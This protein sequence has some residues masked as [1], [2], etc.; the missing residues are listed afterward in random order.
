[1][2]LKSYIK[3]LIYTKRDLFII[4][5]NNINYSIYYFNCN[6]NIF[7]ITIVFENRRFVTRFIFMFNVVINDQVLF[8]F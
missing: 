8:L 2:T 1:M 7:I 4:K 3:D 6:V 5:I